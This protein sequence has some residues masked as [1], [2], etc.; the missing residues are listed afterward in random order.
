MRL[1]SRPVSKHTVLSVDPGVSL[2]LPG[3]QLRRGGS[4]EEISRG[5]PRSVRSAA[6]PSAEQKSSCLARQN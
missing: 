3:E 1:T 2:L 6:G 4:S 5:A